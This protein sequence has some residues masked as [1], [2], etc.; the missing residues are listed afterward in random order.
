MIILDENNGL[1]YTFDDIKIDISKLYENGVFYEE[2]L[3]LYPGLTYE[4]ERPTFILKFKYKET[5]FNLF[6]NGIKYNLIDKSITGV[7]YLFTHLQGILNKYNLKNL[8]YRANSQN[9]FQSLEN[10]EKI[11]KFNFLED[12]IIKETKDDE[13]YQKI[14][15]SM[16]TIYNKNNFTLFKKI[17]N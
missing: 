14:Y 4:V 1:F 13:E 12:I 6:I 8:I 9:E 11:E 10:P 17:Y 16:N 15:N 7:F 3:Q 2:N 5:E